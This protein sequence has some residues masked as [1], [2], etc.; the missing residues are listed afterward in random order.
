M[1]FQKLQLDF[2]NERQGKLK[3]TNITPGFLLSKIHW[4]LNPG[5]NPYLFLGL[6]HQTHIENIIDH[7]SA[8]TVFRPLP[9][10][11]GLDF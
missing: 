2:I 5:N 4:R 1:T 7:N 10:A 9:T 3:I 6:S 8:K 11:K